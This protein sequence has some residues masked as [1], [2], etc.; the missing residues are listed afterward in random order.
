MP[1]TR[2]YLHT[3]LCAA[4]AAWAGCILIK[5]E[6]GEYC[7]RLVPKSKFR[8]CDAAG[9]LNCNKFY[10]QAKRERFYNI[11]RS[12]SYSLMRCELYL[13]HVLSRQAKHLQ[14]NKPLIAN[15]HI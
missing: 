9:K 14:F 3:L 2:R 15:A 11:E 1:F 13:R 7:A 12:K 5:A 4:S 6:Y 10:E 8:V